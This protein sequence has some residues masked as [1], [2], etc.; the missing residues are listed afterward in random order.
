MGGEE[1]FENGICLIEWGEMIEPIL[2]SNYIKI[3]F[4]KDLSNENVRIL[5]IELFGNATLS[6]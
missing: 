6:L 5:D 1:Y 3:I 2:P 4:H